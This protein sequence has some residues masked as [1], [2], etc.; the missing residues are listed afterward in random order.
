[1]G[2]GRKWNEDTYQTQISSEKFQI[3]IHLFDKDKKKHKWTW[4]TRVGQFNLK[5]N[6]RFAFFQYFQTI[7]KHIKNPSNDLTIGWKRLEI[8]NGF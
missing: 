2:N 5:K 8:I 1:M 3:Q 4:L 7:E 6:I